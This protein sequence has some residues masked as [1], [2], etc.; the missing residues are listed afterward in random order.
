MFVPRFFR[1]KTSIVMA[2]QFPEQQS[3]FANECGLP[4]KCPMRLGGS[5]FKLLFRQRVHFAWLLAAKPVPA[6]GQFFACGHGERIQS[7]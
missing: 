3:I 5:D 2:A 6:A 7:S 4:K 1:S